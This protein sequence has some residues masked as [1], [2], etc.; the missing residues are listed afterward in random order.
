LA[1]LMLTA[2]DIEF[3]TV[4]HVADASYS[5][6]AVA[7]GPSPVTVRPMRARYDS[8]Q[9]TEDNTK[10][11][12]NAD[13]LSARAANSP[14]VRQILRNRSRYE[15]ANNNYAKGMLSTLAN[16]IIGTGPTLQVLTSD[17]KV[18]EW[19]EK[20]FNGWARAAAWGAKLW[21]ARHA[22]SVDGEAFGLFTTNRRLDTPVKLDLLLVEADRIGDGVTVSL[23]LRETDGLTLDEAGNVISYK[24]LPEHPGDLGFMAFSS[25]ITVSAD[26]M[27]HMFRVERPEQLRGIPDITPGL[28]LYPV[29]RRYTYAA[30]HAA[31]TAARISGVLQ[32]KFSPE[33]APSV[34]ELES[35]D[36]RINEWMT[37]PEGWELHQMKSEHPATTYPQFKKEVIIE[38]AR[39][40]N[41]PAGIALG[42]SEGYNY[43]SGKLDHVG[44]FKSISIEQDAVERVAC[45]PTLAKWHAEARMIPG[46]MPEAVR[47]AIPEHSWIFDGQEIIDPRENTGQVEA[48]SNG[49]DS[50]A[51]LH[52]KRGLRTDNVFKANAKALGVTV[53]EYQKLLMRKWFGPPAKPA[54]GEAIDEETG[55][56]V[57]A[58]ARL[59]LARGVA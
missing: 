24:L 25:P 42:T 32:T 3:G 4:V 53:P 45:A 59:T 18:N 58:C 28:M 33:E 57:A 31:E 35:M 21:T 48:L 26:R 15:V 1:F 22:Q 44:F 46:Y 41:M 47:E 38:A 40:I 52:A 12:A 55:E 29:L 5:M 49:L 7:A 11:F 27:F 37:M 2:P 39:G 50:I 19:Y 54:D 20:E 51:R 10:Y 43:S 8:A 23:D 9:T 17:D 6:P 36:L 34:P 14:A 13:G 56:T 30:L 16:Y